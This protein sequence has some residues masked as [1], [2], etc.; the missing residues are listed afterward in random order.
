MGRSQIVAHC[1]AR[2]ASVIWHRDPGPAL[3]QGERGHRPGPLL[4]EGPKI[5][6]TWFNF[7]EQKAMSRLGSIFLNQRAA[8]VLIKALAVT[9]TIKHLDHHLLVPL[10]LLTNIY[11]HCFVT[12]ID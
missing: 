4:T 9:N 7:L 12:R 5:E 6:Q 11:S 8:G 2:V 1:A 10:P 3:G